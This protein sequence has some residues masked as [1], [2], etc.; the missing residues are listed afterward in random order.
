M[1]RIWSRP[2]LADLIR[3]HDF[4]QPVS[5]R[6]ADSVVKALDAA[7]RRLQAFPR[8][9]SRLDE[10]APREVRRLIVGDYELRY[11]IVDDAIF[12][13]RIWHGKEDR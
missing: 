4:L 9:G 6:A 8:I 11:E 2:A 5:P 10:Y 7:A 13:L 3:L 1:K 12:V